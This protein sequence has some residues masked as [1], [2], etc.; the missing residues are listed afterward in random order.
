MPTCAILGSYVLDL[1]FGLGVYGAWIG[2]AC[3]ECIRCLWM[4][5]RLR[6]RKWEKK[7]LVSS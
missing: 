2:M 4:I 7:A 5:A 3:D 1:H 6:S